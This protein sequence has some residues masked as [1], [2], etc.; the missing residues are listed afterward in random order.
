MRFIAV[1]LLTLFISF[2]A[3][4]EDKSVD[5]D[6]AAFGQWPVL[7]EGR[8]KPLQSVARSIF[9]IITK[10][11][12]LNDMSAMEWMTHSLFEPS[13]TITKPFIK[14]GSKTF[15][16][17]PERDSHYHSMNEVMTA[18]NPHRDLLLA[19]EQRNEAELTASQKEMLKLYQAVSL[20]NQIIQ[21]FS[22]VLPL[23]GGQDAPF[24]DGGGNTTQRGLIAEGGNGNVLI[25]IIADDN[26]P[27]A[28]FV[29]LWQAI[30]N[31]KSSPFIDKIKLMAAAWAE[32]DIETWNDIAREGAYKSQN[33]AD[34]D[35]TR[36]SLEY[37]YG[38]MQP[39]LWAMGFY[40][41]GSLLILLNGKAGLGVISLGF[42]IHFAALIVRSY[43]LMRPPTGTLYETILFAA[44][45]VIGVAL[46]IAFKSKTPQTGFLS[47]SA[48]SATLLI[49]ISRG[50]IEGDS[51][52]VLVAVLNTNFWLSTH[53]TTIIIG[54]AFC[55]MAAVAAHMVLWNESETVKK[56]LLPLTLFAL[57][58][59]SVGTLLGGIWADQ[60]WGRFW[61][62]DPK[63]NGALLIVLW[64]IW[65]L[66]G[67][68]SGHFKP[69][70][71]AA[72]LALTNIMVALTWFGVNLL[73]VGLHSY[74]FISGIAWGL[75]VYIIL[76][77]AIVAF[78]YFR[79]RV[80]HA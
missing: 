43:I 42:F 74:G 32:N 21:S 68:L 29:S 58:F 53:V 26:N 1:F 77:L 51:F 25:K 80:I 20:Y 14:V 41:A 12:A 55:V 69:R 11:G 27:S 71:F 10:E 36:L 70:A 22:A 34:I 24:I 8:V 72:A 61:G 4:A 73:G 63:E 45:I 66:H 2:S 39:M 47:A 13:S 18:L 3:I 16:D 78:L 75:G 79:S 30:E 57:L 54:Y 17:L 48:A 33:H 60:S 64:L 44:A 28:P 5:P 9:Y 31:D 76:Q 7:H 50:F 52:N 59:T 65:V 56:L 46:L 62:W 15:L 40:I 6:Y 67:R 38:A 35:T 37:A 19:L 49:F 23:N